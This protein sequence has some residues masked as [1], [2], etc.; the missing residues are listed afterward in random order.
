MK[1]ESWTRQTWATQNEEPKQTIKHQ[2]HG[3][4]HGLP[5]LTLETQ[6]IMGYSGP[7]QA[8]KI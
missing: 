4:T 3:E 5:I 7:T 8:R 6:R 2:E 1:H